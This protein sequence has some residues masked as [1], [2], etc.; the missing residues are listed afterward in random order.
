MRVNGMK[1]QIILRALLGLPIGITITYFISIIISII[2]GKGFY[3]AC[4]PALVDMMGNE[5][6]A[7][8]LQVLLGAILGMV[9]SIASIIWELENWTLLKQTVIYFVVVSVWML[10]IAYFTYWMEHSW[11]G[12][13]TYFGIFIIIFGII[14]SIVFAFGKVKV[15]RM[16]TRIA[17]FKK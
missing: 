11:R 3:V 7:V 1:K 13:V 5:I 16:N 10:P 12:F 14:W 6:N 15:K 17:S 9:F 4:V 2:Y 8:I